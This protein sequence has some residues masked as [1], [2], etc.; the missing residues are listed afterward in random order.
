MYSYY[1]LYKNSK[2]PVTYRVKMVSYAKQHGIKKTAKLFKTTAK[3]VRKWVKRFE[4]GEKSALK[5]K[6]KRPHTSP[7]Q[8]K[9]YW[10]FKIED[11][12]QA[13]KKDNKPINATYI[14]KTYFI[15]YSTK[16]ILRVMKKLN[17]AKRPEK[18]KYLPKIKKKLA[19]SENI[20]VDI[21][22]IDDI[23]EGL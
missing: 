7:S 23:S 22:H 19:T 14:K 15:P 1:E 4:D 8:I 16:T 21:K 5:D 20:Q 6:S 11:I 10:Y 17:F 9:P 18:R 12:C 2:N 13:A 3:T